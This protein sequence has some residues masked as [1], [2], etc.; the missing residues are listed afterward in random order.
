MITQINSSSCFN[1][2]EYLLSKIPVPIESVNVTLDLEEC[3]DVQGTKMEPIVHISCT[4]ELEMKRR[5][6]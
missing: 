4:K 5:I 3:I 1:V 6:L 2:G